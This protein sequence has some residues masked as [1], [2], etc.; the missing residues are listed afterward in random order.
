MTDVKTFYNAEQQNSTT[1]LVLNK[2]SKMNEVLMRIKN[3]NRP[4]PPESPYLHLFLLLKQAANNQ[5]GPAMVEPIDGEIIIKLA[6]PGKRMRKVVRRSNYRMTGKFPSFKCGRMMHWESKYELAAF[7]ILETCSLVKSYAEQPALLRYNDKDRVARL[8]YPDI[9]VE[10]KNGSSIFIEVKPA[11]ASV[12]LD[13]AERTD[14][15]ERLLKPQGYHYLM[16]LPEQLESMS[17]LENAKHLL[18]FSKAHMP[19]SIWELVRRIY[20]KHTSVQLSTLVLLLEHESARSWIYKMILSGVLA[21][22]LSL[23]L[24]AQTQVSWSAKGEA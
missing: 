15:L 4:A 23:P 7:H 6:E 12:D 16:I 21:C 17:Y 3:N 1:Q 2:G 11:T 9:L 24:S 20:T 8:H 22:D 5:F 19:E 13:L 14:V 10:L 18:Y